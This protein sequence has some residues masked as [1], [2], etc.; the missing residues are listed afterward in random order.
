LPPLGQP[1][2]PFFREL[3]QLADANALPVR[4]MGMSGD[5]AAAIACGSTAVRLGTAFFG[6]RA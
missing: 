1:P 2:E 6:S 3:V 4:S 5:F